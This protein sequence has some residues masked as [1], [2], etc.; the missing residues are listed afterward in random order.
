MTLAHP[1]RCRQLIRLP[2]RRWGR[3]FGSLSR[4][5]TKNKRAA[6]SEWHSS[7]HCKSHKSHN[8]HLLCSEQTLQPVLSP[9]LLRQTW[10]CVVCLND[11]AHIPP[12]TQAFFFFA[13]IF[14][15]GVTCCN[16]SLLH[17]MHKVKPLP[18]DRAHCHR[19]IDTFILAVSPLVQK[20]SH[21]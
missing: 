13:K 6:S 3:Y 15:G 18:L 10:I 1:L 2:A 19:H 17:T 5:Q 11:V 9:T 4:W 14:R 8:V 12:K 16:K 20:V 21:C 7:C